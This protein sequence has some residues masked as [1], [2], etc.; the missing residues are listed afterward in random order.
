M[1]TVATFNGSLTKS[2]T[3]TKPEHKGWFSGLKAFFGEI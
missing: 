2:A 1:K 3:A